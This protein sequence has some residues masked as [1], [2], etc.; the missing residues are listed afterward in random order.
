MLDESTLGVPF[1]TGTLVLVSLFI[2]WYRRVDPQLD[3]IP[4][5]GFSNPILSY[6]SAYKLNFRTALMLKEGYEKIKPGLF[7]VPTFRQWIVVPSG[8]ELIEEIMK[9]PDNILSEREPLEA[10]LQSKYTIRFL[11]MDDTYHRTV[12]RSKMT[13][14]IAATFDQVHDEL[15]DALGDFIPTVD[16]EWVKVSILPTIKRIVCRTSSRV[17]VGAPL[18]RDHNYQTMV[19][20]FLDNLMKSAFILA[21][22]PELLKPI[23]AQFVSKTMEF[24]KPI[25]EERSAKMK[26]FGENWDELRD[27]LMWLMSDAKGVERSLEG[28]SRRLLG[29]DFASIHT[30]TITFTQTLYR[31]L[32]H[33]EYIE[34]LRQEAESV[35]HKI[36]SFVRET[37]RLDGPM[38]SPGIESSCPTSLHFSNGVTIPAGT[39]IGIPVHS[40]HMDE[41]LYPNAQEFD[42]FRFYKLREKE[43]DDVLETRHQLVTTSAELLGSGLGD[44]RANQ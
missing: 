30:T 39:R 42:G 9:A 22:F 41:E 13:R 20:N 37:Q 29:L 40:V 17:V 35:M 3:A 19:I 21:C 26:E 11:N 34:P 10:L 23:V 4:T 1:L 24:I 12:M 7:K 28:W 8:S 31:L 27:M 16:Q 38:I 44:T 36:D 25:V 15:V 43:G 32:A 14:N 6:F 33:P 2:A 5:V 18:C